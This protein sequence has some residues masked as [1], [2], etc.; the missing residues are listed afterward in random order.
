[1]KVQKMLTSGALC[2]GTLLF[3][4]PAFAQTGTGA[5]GSGNGTTTAPTPATS[6][7]MGSKGSMGMGSTAA[8]APAAGGPS[9]AQIAAIVVAANT[10]DINAAKMAKSHT[11]NKAVKEFASTMIR[12]HEGNNKAAKALVTKLHVTPEENDTSKSLTDGGKENMAALKKMKGAEFDKAYVEHEVAYHQQVVDAINNTLIP[13]A[14]NADLKAL[15]VQ[16]GPVIQAHLEHAK[17]LQTEMGTGGSG[18]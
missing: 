10:V 3:A 8:T 1:M 13:N 16:T 9:D 7:T 6:G 5:M 17:H 11:K 18:E 4:A 12:D 14:K 2:L 15:L